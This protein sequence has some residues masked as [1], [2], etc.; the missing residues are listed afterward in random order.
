[1]QSARRD[2]WNVSKHDAVLTNAARL[3]LKL[4]A[5]ANDLRG[6]PNTRAIA[7]AKLAKLPPPPPR[8][9]L[10]HEPPPLP[11]TMAEWRMW[12]CIKPKRQAR[13][14]AH[15]SRNLIPA[16]P[17]GRT[18]GIRGNADDYTERKSRTRAHPQGGMSGFNCLSA[19]TATFTV[20][21]MFAHSTICCFRTSPVAGKLRVRGQVMKRRS[22]CQPSKVY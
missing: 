11:R 14:R 3:K 6:E 18:P 16:K 5:L 13:R 10:A 7:A 8:S 20:C 19:L 4:E 12:R 9:G 22:T 21:A 17:D 1:M 15:G 2:R